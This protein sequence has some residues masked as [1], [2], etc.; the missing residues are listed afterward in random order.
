MGSAPPMGLDELCRDLGGGRVGRWRNVTVTGLTTDS[1]RTRPGDLFVA[2]AGETAHGAAFAADALARG[3]VAVVGAPGAPLPGGV[4]ALVH[5]RPEVILAELAAR[6]YRRPARQ[7][8]VIGVTG[9]NGKTTTALMAAAMLR[10]SGRPTSHWTTTEV[11]VGRER[12]RPY[13]TTPPPPD[14]HRFLRAAVD[15]GSTHVVMEVSSHGIALNRLQGVRFAAGAVTNVTADHLDFHGDLAAYVATKRAF[16]EQLDADATAVLGADDPVAAGFARHLRARPVTFGTASDATLQACRIDPRS[17]RLRFELRIRGLAP[18]VLTV[19]L[20]MPGR[21]N[22]LNAMA[23]L[24][25]AGAVGVPP[26]LARDA[27]AA[28]EPPPRRIETRSVGP[29]TMVNDVAMNEGSCDA[30]LQAVADLAPAQLVVV[31]AVRGHRGPEVSRAIARVLARWAPR[32]GF[33]PLV[34]SLS[35]AH[36]AR[37]AVD[38]AVRTAELDALLGQCA[39]LGLDTQV[40]AELDDAIRAAADRLE[41]GGTLLLLGT[42]GMDDGPRLATALLARRAGVDPGTLPAY[43]SPS[44]GGD[45]G[46]SGP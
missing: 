27:L 22:A 42:F 21:H 2:V 1:R 25:L 9:T 18:Q 16:V 35:R 39:I 41:E 4:P 19:D 32:L 14:L 33:G 36:L 7:L 6:L 17:T 12:F 29:Y 34:V 37:A 31:Q 8:T 20:G 26:A 44:Y 45:E 10:H 38:H 46:G 43:L 24:A 28:F 15:A 11:A 30:V 13:W 23:A 40:H 3:A 5:P